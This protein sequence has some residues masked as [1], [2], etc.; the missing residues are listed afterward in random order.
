MEQTRECRNKVALQHRSQEQLDITVLM[1]THTMQQPLHKMHLLRLRPA[2][3]VLD[4]HPLLFVD[5][6]WQNNGR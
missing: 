1:M 4:A 3:K 2:L 5:V 6:L